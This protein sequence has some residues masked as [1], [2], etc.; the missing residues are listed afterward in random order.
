MQKF[1]RYTIYNNNIYTI[2]VYGTPCIMKTVNV[3]KLKKED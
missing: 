3:T 1:K 2:L